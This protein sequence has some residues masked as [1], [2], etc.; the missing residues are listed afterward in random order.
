[1][2]FRIAPQPAFEA[3]RVKTKKRAKNPDY[4]AWLHSLPCIV[5]GRNDVEAAH[6][7]YE[8]PAYGK[9]GRGKSQKEEDR[10]AVPLCA[11]EHRRQHSMNERAY[12]RSVGI[13]P[14]FVA[15][16]LYG[17]YPNTELALFIIR[18]IERRPI[19]PA[20]TNSEHEDCHD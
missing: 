15:L 1:M 19:W 16:A 8:A 3:H 4:L 5:T 20:S 9:L 12:W 18:H 13:D 2:M 7:S 6:V 17:A 14:C 10:W 11:E